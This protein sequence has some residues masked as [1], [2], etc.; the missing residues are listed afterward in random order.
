[1]ER[2]DE[3]PDMLRQQSS[4]THPVLK[5]SKWSPPSRDGSRSRVLYFYVSGPLISSGCELSSYIHQVRVNKAGRSSGAGSEPRDEM[6]YTALSGDLC[7]KACAALPDCRF[8]RLLSGS[9]LEM[10]LSTLF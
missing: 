9:C 8:P 2:T 4:Y 1:M 6:L 10:T 5:F 7:N 3:V